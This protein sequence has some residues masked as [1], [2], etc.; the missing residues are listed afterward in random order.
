MRYFAPDKAGLTTD[1]VL[2][3]AIRCPTPLVR[4]NI[5]SVQNIASDTQRKK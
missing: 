1:S 5:S 3:I 4:A 2:S